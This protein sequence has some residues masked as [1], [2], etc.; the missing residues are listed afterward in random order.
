[1][2]PVLI[3]QNDPHE[4]AGLLTS[5]FAKVKMRQE[6]VFGQS[7]EHKS[8]WPDQYCGLVVLGGVQGAYE[9][10]RYPYIQNEIDLCSRFMDSGKPVA[11]FCLGA[12]VLACAVGGEVVPN[13]QKEI[14]WYD[15]TLTRDAESDPLMFDQPKIF[16]AYHF[17][18]DIIK[19][20]PGA[21]NLASSAM[22]HWQL[23]RHGSNVYGFQYHA[24]AD[25]QLIEIMC[26]NNSQY[27]ATNNINAEIVIKESRA[28]IAD[29]ERRCAQVLARWV[30]L[31][32]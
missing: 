27:M 19:S 12:Q 5:I 3:I 8:S 7:T 2:L 30:K 16:P 13:E 1:M 18:G 31:L 6:T 15:L 23:F 17:H 4:G 32:R 11:G 28:R 10:D 14:G 24:E 20:A 26:R 25:Q 21:V 9:T 29:Y 22:T